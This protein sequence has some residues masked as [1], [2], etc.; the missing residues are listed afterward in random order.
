[1]H[2]VERSWRTSK[3][4]GWRDAQRQE[5]PGEECRQKSG[6][7]GGFGFYSRVGGESSELSRL[8]LKGLDAA[9]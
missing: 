7:R 2:S 6:R 4:E 8:E 9:D 1:M 5:Q 3:G